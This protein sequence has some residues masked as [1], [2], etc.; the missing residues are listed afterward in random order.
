MHVLKTATTHT[1]RDSQLPFHN[2]EKYFKYIKLF[3][4]YQLQNKRALF[5]VNYTGIFM[6]AGTS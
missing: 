1:R 5:S 2:F 3:S 4:N 6:S